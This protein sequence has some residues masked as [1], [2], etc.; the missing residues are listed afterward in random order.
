MNIN[1]DLIFTT[2][3]IGCEINKYQNKTLKNG[4]IKNTRD[5]YKYLNLFILNYK[6]LN[7]MTIY[8]YLFNKV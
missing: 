2:T 5:L 4:N 3:P 1:N 8:V 6:I 7:G